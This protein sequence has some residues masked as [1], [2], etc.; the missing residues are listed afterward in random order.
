MLQA[1]ARLWQ[2]HNAHVF[3]GISPTTRQQFDNLR[4]CGDTLTGTHRQQTMPINNSLRLT[5]MLFCLQA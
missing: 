1:D 5:M 4:T 2:Y 3:A